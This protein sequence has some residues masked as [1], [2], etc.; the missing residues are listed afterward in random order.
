MKIARECGWI[1]AP[2]ITNLLGFTPRRKSLNHDMESA[3]AGVFDDL[4][5]VRQ[6]AF[7]DTFCDTFELADALN[8]IV[9]GIDES[10]AAVRDLAF[11]GHDIRLAVVRDDDAGTLD[12]RVAADDFRDLRRMHKHALDLG[13]LVGAP[14]PTGK[15][16][17]GAPARTDT[18]QQFLQIAGR[19][20]DQRDVGSKHGHHHLADL[21][22]GNGI[23]RART[24]NFDDMALV[25]DKTVAG[26]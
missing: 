23:A 15:T 10:I 24:Q 19:E 3:F 11:H 5:I 22:V 7:R 1:V 21:V 8:R 6:R 9:Q 12:F 20:T 13:R 26:R 18:R 14:H 16:H 2:N 4:A 17:V 25:D